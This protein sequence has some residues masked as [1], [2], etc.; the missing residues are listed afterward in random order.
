MN[1]RERF[2][3]KLSDHLK[4]K[5]VCVFPMKDAEEIVAM[6]EEAL[7]QFEWFDGP[8]KILYECD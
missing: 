5:G 4:N 7:F 1:S 3:D 6:M 8:S 2:I